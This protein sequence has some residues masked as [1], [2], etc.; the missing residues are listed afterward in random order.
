MKKTIIVVLALVF[1]A[2]LALAGTDSPIINDRQQT[3][4]DRIKEGTAS[5]ELTKGEA[6][7]LKND[8][9]NIQSEKK[10]MKSDGKFTKTERKDVKKQL[11]KESKKIYR[12]K[13]NKKTKADPKGK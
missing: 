6:K 4:K 11:N 10:T 13:H 3:Q 2:S 7:T 8:E 5:G 9:K 1:V 12:L